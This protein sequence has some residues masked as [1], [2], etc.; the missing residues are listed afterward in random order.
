MNRRGS[1]CEDEPREKNKSDG[2]ME[3]RKGKSLTDRTRRDDKKKQRAEGREKLF[4]S[5][6]G[7]TAAED[8]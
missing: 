2:I 6:G 1:E 4:S 3:I 5:F 7:S 8:V